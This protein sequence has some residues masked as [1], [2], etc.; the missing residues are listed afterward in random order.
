MDDGTVAVPLPSV[1]NAFGI[2]QA[3]DRSR[4]LVGRV[5]SS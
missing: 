2:E 1:P 3:G 5:P 4:A